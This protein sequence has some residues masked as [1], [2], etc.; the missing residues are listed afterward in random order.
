MVEA[1]TVTNRIKWGHLYCVDKKKLGGIM[2]WASFYEVRT[3]EMVLMNGNPIAV[4]YMKRLGNYFPLFKVENILRSAL[5]SKP[6][7]R[8]IQREWYRSSLSQKILL[9]WSGQHLFLTWILSRAF[10][11]SLRSYYTHRDARLTRL[12]TSSS[13]PK[14][15]ATR[16]LVK[17]AALC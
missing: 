10:K 1:T 12:R 9:L 3:T 6:T 16:W 2:V 15:S 4:K 7:D 5:F 14:K 13:S 17:I 11:K 8:C